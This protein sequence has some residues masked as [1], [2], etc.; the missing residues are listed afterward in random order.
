MHGHHTVHRNRAIF[1]QTDTQG[2]PRP[3]L[4]YDA[5]HEK[6]FGYTLGKSERESVE[7]VEREQ[8]GSFADDKSNE[9]VLQPLLRES[10]CF[11]AT[12]LWDLLQSN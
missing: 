4:I 9:A 3:C 11:C 1:T 5:R 2:K 10:E 6:G 12:R 7:G 8:R